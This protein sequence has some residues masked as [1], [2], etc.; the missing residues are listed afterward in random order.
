LTNAVYAKPDANAP[1]TNAYNESMSYDK[2]GNIT[3]LLRNGGQDQ[4]VNQPVAIDNLTYQYIA[5]TNQLLTVSDSSNSTEGFKDVVSTQ[6]YNYDN[7]GNQ[8][9]DDNKGI[10]NIKYNHLNLPTEIIFTTTPTIKKINYIYDAS[11]DKLQKVVTEGPQVITT[12]YLDGFQYRN[13]VLQF[14]PHAEGY[15][16]NTQTVAPSGVKIDNYNYVYNYLDHLGNVRLSYTWDVATNA[17]K[18]IEENG[19]YP[20]GLK[21]SGYNGSLERHRAV[22]NDTKVE[23]RGV[24]SGGSGATVE[25]SLNQYKFNGQEWQSELAL[26]LYDMDMRDYD[27]AIARWTGLDPVTHFSQSPYNAFDGNPVFWA[28]PSG[29]DGI[30]ITIDWNQ[31]GN[32]TT[33]IITPIYATDVDFDS[34]PETGP[35]SLHGTELGAAIDFGMNYNSYAIL[36]QTEVYT[37]FYTLFFEKEG[38]KF[39]YVTPVDCGGMCGEASVKKTIDA[40]KKI[41]QA[42]ITASGHTHPGQGVIKHA[43]LLRD[44]AESIRKFSG[45]LKGLGSGDITN[46]NDQNYVYGHRIDAYLAVPNGGLLH[47]N[48]TKNYTPKYVDRVAQYS[49]DNPVYKGLPSDPNLGKYRLNNINPSPMIPSILITQ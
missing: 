25:A 48:S 3:N 30:T 9:K 4:P 12:D 19:Y 22:A 31:L 28:D 11:G 44:T 47:Y 37:T 26:N 42:V 16:I 38:Q 10:T 21:H 8:N 43:G 23:L 18:I 46:Y 2:N 15:V 20:Y 27:P 41:N 34:A 35:G 17:L 49:Y 14:F 24:P 29:A 5:N 7:F 6:D 33:T 1:L 45:D 40:V 32:N 39:G 13:A 36:K